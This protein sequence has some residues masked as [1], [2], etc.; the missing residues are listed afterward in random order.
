M[1]YKVLVPVYNRQ[2][3]QRQKDLLVEQLQKAK[4]DMVMLT[5][6]RVICNE[7]MLEEEKKV[8]VENKVYF[9][10]KGLTVGAWL[11]PSIGYGGTTTKGKYDNNA[12]EIYT[13]IKNFNGEDV[14]AYCPLDEKFVKDFIQTI[15]V[16]C[17]TGVSFILFEDDYTVSG[18]KSY[19]FGCACPLHMKLYEEL[20]G[21]PVSYDELKE[22]LY[23]GGPN[24]IRTMW[25]HATSQTL[26]DLTVKIEEAVHKDYPNVRIGLSANSSSFCAEGVEITKLAKIIAGNNRPFIRLTGAPYWK[27]AL[28]F[29]TNVEAIRL[30]SFWCSDE[31]IELVSEGD[32]FP[33]PRH[34]IPANY[35]E[36]YDMMI[37]ADGKTSGILKYMLDYTSNADYETGYVDRHCRNEVHYEEIERRFAGKKG[38][39]LNVFEC[40]MTSEKISYN[41][42]FTPNIWFQNGFLPTM[43]QELCVD[44]S[45]PTAYGDGESASIVFGESAYFVTDDVLSRG[46]V[47]DGM[48]ALILQEKGI[49]VGLRRW[50]TASEIFAEYF[51]EEE[52]YIS[53]TLDN[54]GTIYRFELD[55]NAEIK[56]VFLEGSGVLANVSGDISNC[57]HCP[58]CYYYKNKQGQRFLVYSF[59]AH[60][61]RVRGGWHKGMFRHYLRQDQLIRQISRL[62]G[63]ALPAV[64]PGHP[65]LYLLCKKDMD[66]MAVGIWN[67]FPDEVLD[68]VITLDREYEKVDFY[69][70]E[71]CLFGNRVVLR[72][73][74][75]PF[76][77]ALFTVGQTL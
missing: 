27:H 3:T 8:F 45:I 12:D 60:T 72:E 7:Q 30:Q 62:Q 24:D 15:K 74:I 52:E 71:G 34:W 9:E 66:S 36:H 48:A 14:Y 2:F 57:P 33:R 59:V 19:D 18:G 53:V 61:V 75:P 50:E 47:L 28:S 70:C 64:C 5:F 67:P 1:R 23:S 46:V 39:G 31:E 17:S 37:R 56:S 22:A 35:L 76:G 20:L 16:L 41:E 10:S 68:P 21:R 44:N 6:Q 69:N 43:S 58:A 26:E 13:R 55:K 40:T 32:T 65:Q 29:A 63:H 38:V 77:F 73:Q 25:H 54:P 51:C 11:F 49:D 4:T 42:V